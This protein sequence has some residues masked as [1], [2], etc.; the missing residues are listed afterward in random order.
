MILW[1]KDVAI[2]ELDSFWTYICRTWLIL[3]LHLPNSMHF[4][5]I[6]FKLHSF[7]S[8]ICRTSL[9]DLLLSNLTHCGFTFV[10]LDKFW[11]YICWTWP[12]SWTCI[13]RIWVI[14][15]LHLSNSNYPQGV[16]PIGLPANAQG[17]AAHQTPALMNV[18]GAARSDDPN[19]PPLIFPLFFADPNPFQA[20]DL[21]EEPF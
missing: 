21:E 20:L 10:E 18:H 7:W 16:P 3:D 17:A 1:Q 6:F 5:L 11:V 15:D 14:F 4:G 8:Y 13:C 9:M 2:V 19:I 12:I